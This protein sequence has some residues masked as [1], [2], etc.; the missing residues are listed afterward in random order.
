MAALLT[1]RNCPVSGEIC[2]VG[3]GHVAGF[4]VGGTTGFYDPALTIEAVRDHLGEIRDKAGFTV[5]HG[6]ADEMAALFA[7]I[8][9]QDL[10]R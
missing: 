8:A 10:S 3:A 2:T 6:P 4:F 5:P 9:S 1:H 7:T